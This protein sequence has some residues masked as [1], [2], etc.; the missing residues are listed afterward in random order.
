LQSNDACSRDPTVF[1]DVLVD[2]YFMVQWQKY[3]IGWA[4]AVGRRGGASEY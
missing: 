2:L 4:V 3:M 1:F